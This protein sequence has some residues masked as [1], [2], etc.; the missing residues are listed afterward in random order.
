MI[1]A[2]HTGQV[3]SCPVYNVCISSVWPQ[4]EHSN[5]IASSFKFLL[6]ARVSRKSSNEFIVQKSYNS[7][8]WRTARVKSADNV[9]QCVNLGLMEI[10]SVSNLLDINGKYYIGLEQVKIIQ[11][12]FLN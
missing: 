5:I 10:G 1:W 12:I 8:C 11:V 6:C 3:T 7:Q 2:L 4:S 9:G